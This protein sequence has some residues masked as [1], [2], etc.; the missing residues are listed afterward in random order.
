MY[1]IV[2]PLNS[3]YNFTISPYENEIIILDHLG[4]MRVL[5]N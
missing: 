5:R 3:L 2:S 4:K 1:N